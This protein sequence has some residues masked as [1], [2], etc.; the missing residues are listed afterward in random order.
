MCIIHPSGLKK[1]AF[2]FMKRINIFRFFEIFDTIAIKEIS[3]TSIIDG[4]QHD[5]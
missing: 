5:S 2:S 1:M 3:F 4:D